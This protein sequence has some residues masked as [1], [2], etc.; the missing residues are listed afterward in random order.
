MKQKKDTA[1]INN[2]LE[3]L[4][5][6][7]GDFWVS[8][9]YEN[10]G[11][12]SKWLLYSEW[13]K[14]AS[15]NKRVLKSIFSE[16]VV[17]DIE[18]K[19]YEDIKSSLLK[20]NL[21]FKIFDSGGRGI[22][23]HLFFSELKN[24]DESIRPYIKEFII[25]KLSF[26]R[27]DKKKK[28]NKNLIGAEFYQHR[29]GSKKKLLFENDS[30]YYPDNKLGK[31]VLDFIKT[32][33]EKYEGNLIEGENKS[34]IIFRSKKPCDAISSLI[35]KGMKHPYRNP[36]ANFIVQQLRDYCGYDKKDCFEA[37][38]EYNSNCEEPKD[39]QKLMRDLEEQYKRKYNIN[40][41]TLIERGLCHW[42]HKEDC[43]NYKYF[44]GIE[45]KEKIS[46]DVEEN[47]NKGI[48]FFEDKL[49]SAEIFHTIQPTYYDQARIFWLWDKNQCKWIKVDETDIL[50][51]ISKMT[52]ANT[53]NSKQKNEILESLKQVGRLKKP[54]EPKKTWV[55]F[56]NK[57]V[58]IE[59]GS[60][61]DADCTNF[62]TNPIPW[63]IGE[64]E[65]TPTMDRI[66]KQW[67]VKENVQDESWVKTLYEILAFSLL[68]YMP[69][70]RIICLI[71][72]GLNGKGT[73][74]RLIEK[75]IGSENTCS[76][77]LDILVK[78]NFEVSK[79]YKKLVCFVGEIDK[80]VFQKTAIIKGIVGDDLM[81]IEFKGKDGFDTHLYAK[82]IIACNQLPETTDKS[83]GFFRRWLIIDFPNRFDEKKDILNEIPDIEYSNLAKKCLRIA[84]ELLDRGEFTNEGS[85]EDRERKY[86]E[87]S[88]PIDKFIEKYCLKEINE[89]V[90]YSE[91]YEKF[92]DFLDSSKLRVQSR[93]EVSKSLEERN[94]KT[95]VMGAK[96]DSG[97][98]TTQKCILGLKW[99]Y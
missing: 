28:D 93:I 56:K 43:P 11:S 38:K 50:N 59:D 19:Q 74:G 95:K 29:E 10:I 48:S 40:C 25:D 37:L 9:Y 87:H 91:F 60:M 47:F 24:Y 72:E 88:N 22:H 78:S 97:A 73:F 21:K 94:F 42:K 15:K 67:M 46:I 70:H 76:T 17:L 35:K 54:Q 65:E 82:P 34:T 27:A 30:E 23:I 45:N 12:W 81:R 83:K 39:E 62:V 49:K 71:G 33:P 84:K 51:L 4:Y 32:L 89:A 99:R 2:I 53:I 5:N 98:N 26:G 44:N 18:N 7:Y 61:I 57:I 20:N 63:S 8:E 31:K 69:L 68:S 77:N 58:D 13:V 66:F 41:N 64:S 14:K 85:I 92:K 90:I 79:L 6:K 36:C 52:F 80:G 96:T 1:S 75:F 3:R 86:E 55:Q 16:E